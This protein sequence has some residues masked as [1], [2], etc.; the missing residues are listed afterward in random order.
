MGDKKAEELFASGGGKIGDLGGARNIELI[1]QLARGEQFAEIFTEALQGLGFH[2]K[3][4][5][6]Q[7]TSRQVGR[8]EAKPGASS[9]EQ[10]RDRSACEHCHK[11]G[12]AKKDC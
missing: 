8:A 2:K 7:G 1:A 6:L 10:P 3:E 4:A 9:K 5:Q 11:M 12:H